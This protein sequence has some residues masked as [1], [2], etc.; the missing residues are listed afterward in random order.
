M[1]PQEFNFCV[2][3]IPY[4]VQTVP[5][6]MTAEYKCPNECLLLCHSSFISAS[7]TLLCSSFA[8]RTVGMTLHQLLSATSLS[9]SLCVAIFLFLSSIFSSD[10]LRF[11]FLCF[12]FQGNMKPLEDAVSVSYCVFFFPDWGFDDDVAE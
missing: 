4:Q 3:C 10:V 2:L 6:M 8:A 1:M 11:M 5:F 9:L 7:R 12:T